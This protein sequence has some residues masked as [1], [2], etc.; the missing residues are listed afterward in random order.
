MKQEK[1]LTRFMPKIAW[2]HIKQKWVEWVRLKKENPSC[3]TLY[4]DDWSEHCG[5]PFQ[6]SLIKLKSVIQ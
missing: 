2:M 1:K 4:I 6:T 3:P 5:P